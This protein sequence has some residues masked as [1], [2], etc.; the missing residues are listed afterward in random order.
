MANIL[1]TNVCNRSCPY[2]FASEK[3][4]HDGDIAQPTDAKASVAESDEYIS[5]ENFQYAL[6]FLK[7]SHSGVISLLGGEPTLHPQFETIMEMA[8]AMD[9]GI[10]IFSNGLMPEKKAELLASMEKV[11]VVVNIN[12]P[13]RTPE[14]QWKRA[15]RTL[16]I[17]GTN[18]SLSFNIYRTD[19]DMRFLVDTILRNKLEPV[20]RFGLAMPILGADNVHIAMKDYRTIGKQLVE[21]SHLCNPY[22]I[23]VNMDCGFVMCMFAPEE[24][25]PL[26]YNGADVNFVCSPII[27]ISPDLKVWSC[28]A[29]SQVENLSLRDFDNRN[30]IV[31]HYLEKFGAYRN[32]GGMDE[33]LECPQLQRQKCTGGCIVHV[34]RS[35]GME[36][37]L[38][39]GK[40][41]TDGN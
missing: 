19:C 12:E 4:E 38:F 6:D 35:F 14:P 20:I 36:E 17:L 11:R 8:D 29:L 13:D 5:L 39:P 18:G 25:G 30:Q 10:K 34:M 41:T 24:I 33:C 9:M 2:C 21:F 7:R 16:E 32:M 15:N 26:I 22:N 28:F 31:N 40:G 23:A 27:D 1:L 3:V 37:K